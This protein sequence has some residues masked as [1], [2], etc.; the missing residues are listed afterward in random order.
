[1]NQ[2]LD[3]TVIVSGVILGEF[4]LASLVCRAIQKL[5]RFFDA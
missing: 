3:P 1:M 2:E 4:F 5:S